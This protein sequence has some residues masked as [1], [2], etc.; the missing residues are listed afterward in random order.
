MKKIHFIGIFL[1]LT[2]ISSSL[3]IYTVNNIIVSHSQNGTAYEYDTNSSH[4]F[5]LT[6]QPAYSVLSSSYG[7]AT[8]FVDHSLYSLVRVVESNST[9]YKI[10]QLHYYPQPL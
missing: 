2:V 8:T 6:D 10:L 1:L 7:T 4:D 5:L 3:M 9:V